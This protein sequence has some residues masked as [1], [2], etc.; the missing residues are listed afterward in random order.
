RTHDRISQTDVSEYERFLFYRGLGDA[1]LPLKLDAGQGGTLNLGRDG[2]DGIRHV[3][4]IRVE[5]GKG[6]YSYH[7]AIRPGETITGAIPSM[8]GAGPIEAVARRL[9]D[10]LAARLVESGLYPKEARAMVNT[11]RTSYFHTEGVRALVVMPQTWT[12]AFIPLEVT[13]RPKNVVRVMV[14]RIELL[15]PE[16][17]RL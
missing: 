10:D 13:P 11:W 14:G 6:A 15:T 4:L 17:E 9:A 1:P 7:P 12:D 5:D 2:P 8:A 3:F 16:R